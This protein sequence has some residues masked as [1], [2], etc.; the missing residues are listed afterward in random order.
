LSS[1][2]L[3]VARCLRDVALG[4][5]NDEWDESSAENR[6]AERTRCAGASS[7]ITSASIRGRTLRGPP[8][9]ATATPSSSLLRDKTREEDDE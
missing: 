5:G 7:C 6:R 9:C 2:N 1:G 8:R 3:H 4:E